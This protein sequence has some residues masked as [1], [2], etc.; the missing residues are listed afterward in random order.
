MMRLRPLARM[1]RVRPLA[2]ML[3][4]RGGLGRCV[5]CRL[6]GVNFHALQTDPVWLDVADNRRRIEGALDVT[7]FERG[8]F[9]VL[10]E[11][12]ETGWSTNAADYANTRD[13]VDWLCSAARSRQVWIQA[14]FAE[15]ESDRAGDDRIANSVA[16]VAPDGSLH[17]VYRK[18]FL[19]PSES[20]TF[21][22]GNEIVIV[23]IG[24][25]RVCPFICYDLR[26]PE[27]WRHAALAGAE[28]F[29]VSSCWP[30]VRREHWRT[31]LVARAVENQCSVVAANRCGT[32]PTTEY[33]GA[34]VVITP[35][36]A[37]VQEVLEGSHA[38]TL[39]FD[40]AAHDAWRANFSALRDA[41][42]SLLGSIT[43][44]RA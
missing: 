5:S 13:S 20:S 7:A 38:A 31:L 33:A 18:N 22:R 8:D 41:R 39:A 4:L 34:S 14:G 32:D 10:P 42:T 28:V 6:C 3:L 17:A 35:L 29:T 44:T 1:M 30:A 27:L 23:D 37:R 24:A 15:H 36:G 9:F 12:C 26:F 21:M 40:R 19:F 43:V 2:R 25:A 16:I 11:M